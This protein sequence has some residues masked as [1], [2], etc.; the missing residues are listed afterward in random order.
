ME[1]T[2]TWRDLLG[3]I[4]SE[5]YQRQRI[6]DAV[7]INPVT[8]I[9]WATGR[10]N[11]R[12]DNLRPLLE[13]LP[14]YRQE[15]SVLIAQ[16]YPQL[17]GKTREADK[18][19]ATVIPSA[20][21]AHVLQAYT[22]SPSILRASTTETLILQQLESQL[23][24]QRKGITIEVAQCVPPARGYK[25]RSLRVTFHRSTMAVE[26]LVEPQTFFLGAETLAGY[27]LNV[28]HPSIMQSE[29]EIARMFPTHHFA[30][31]KSAVA[32]PIILSNRAAG[33]LYISSTQPN[34][35]SQAHLDLI[36][37]YVDL[38]VLSF[39]DNEFYNLS[40]IELSVMPS[41][42]A[43]QP[44]LVTF[45]ARVKQKLLAAAQ[46]RRALTRLQAE[47]N[48]WQELEEELLRLA[49]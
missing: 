13:A 43:Q 7:G 15:L 26:Q 47:Y 36:G 5:P 49:V 11:P 39:E 30:W 1:E 33:S 28:R 41:L 20:F 48:V 44:H 40:D 6:A 34:Y 27:V 19:V 16:E 12:E 23:D 31:E 37:S 17:F 45:Q 42:R 35:F 10:S 21:Y 14:Q 32:Y 18:T 9:R 38:M 25:I 22:D 24:P 8:L 2:Q 3:K 46:E 4:I 29:I